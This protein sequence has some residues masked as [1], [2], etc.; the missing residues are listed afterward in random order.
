MEQGSSGSREWSWKE[1]S[2]EGAWG[3]VW[4]RGVK[5]GKEQQFGGALIETDT[6]T[7]MSQVFAEG[8]GK[9]RNATQI[10]APYWGITS[11][12]H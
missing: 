7:Q 9:I 11:P 3:Q 4:Q 5:G 10:W 1:Q 6:I 2:G 8:L 12:Q